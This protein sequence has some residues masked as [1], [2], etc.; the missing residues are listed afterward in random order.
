VIV[1]NR[2]S[3][4]RAIAEHPWAT[5]Q[6]AALA[7]SV[8]S[9]CGLLA[10]EYD[11]FWFIGDPSVEHQ[12]VTV[13]EA[14]ALTVL[15]AACI[16]VFVH[17]RMQ[18][19]SDQA[20][21]RSQTDAELRRL[22]NEAMRDPLTDLPNRRAVL[23]RLTQLPAPQPHF[24][25]AFFMLDLTDFKR[26]NDGY[27]H[28]VGDSVLQVVSERFKRVA[29]PLD[30]LARLGGDEFAVLSSDLDRDAATA[31]GMRFVSALE[32]PI[33]IDGIAHDIGVSVG[34]ALVP[35]DGC[36]PEEIMINADLAMYRAKAKGHSGLVFFSD[37]DPSKTSVPR[38]VS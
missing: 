19:R 9:V 31:V 26:V 27:G 8:V 24:Q 38:R 15:L 3:V 2:N 17:R 13:L 36:A 10:I 23:A 14:I 22:R 7:V 28:V 37:K 18:E 5:V 4:I 20:A 6:D 30:L 32:N 33:V 25:H 1:T 21:Q 12:H 35:Q 34:V 16:A 29:R 11:L